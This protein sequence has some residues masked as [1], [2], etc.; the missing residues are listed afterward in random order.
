M[1]AFDHST[2]ILKTAL[3]RTGRTDAYRR[4]TSVARRCPGGI[5]ESALRTDVFRFVGE[6]WA[7]FG[8]D[9]Q[10]NAT[11][12]ERFTDSLLPDRSKASFMSDRETTESPGRTKR[13]RRGVD[14][15]FLL[16]SHCGRLKR[17]LLLDVKLLET[18]A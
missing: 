11:E 9:W 6:N 2:S 12:R 16:P 18:I 5:L 3:W 13:A 8:E 14:V 15:A 7:R 1:G 4:G 17:T 10:N